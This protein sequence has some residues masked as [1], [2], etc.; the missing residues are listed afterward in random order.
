MESI[1]IYPYRPGIIGEVVRHH[2]IYYHGHWDFD[3]RFEVQVSR[4]LSEFIN[5]FDETRD[6]FWWAA[7][8]GEFV[9]AIGVDGSRSG[10]GQARIRWFIVTETCQGKGVGA[11]LFEH[12]LRFCAER[13]FEGVY[14]WTFEGLVAARKLY[15]RNGFQLVETEKGVDWGPVIIEQKFE[16]T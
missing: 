13:Q 14:L 2:A 11:Q 8:D 4:E 1:T 5:E 3:A 10:A 15:E 16:L 7:I 9:G 12:A 6:G